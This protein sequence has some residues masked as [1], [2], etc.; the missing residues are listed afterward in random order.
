MQP[1]GWYL[2][3]YGIHRDRWYSDGQPTSLVRDDGIES[4]WAAYGMRPRHRR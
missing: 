1:E 2:D 3:P 4:H